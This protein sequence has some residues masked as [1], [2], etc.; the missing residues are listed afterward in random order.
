VHD[1][2]KCFLVHHGIEYCTRK[3]GLQC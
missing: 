2:A 3:V 1:V